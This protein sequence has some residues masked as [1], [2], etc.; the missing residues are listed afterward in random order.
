MWTLR[1]KHSHS[2][3]IF[4][5]DA[6]AAR[7]ACPGDVPISR[8]LTAQDVH[9]PAVFSNHCGAVTEHALLDAMCRG[10]ALAWATYDA[11]F[12]PILEAYARRTKIPTGDW[13]TCVAEVLEDEGL[14]LSQPGVTRPVSLGAYL[15]AAVRHRYL[16]LK[17]SDL[18]RQRNQSAASEDCS[19]E[20]VVTSLCSE[21]ALRRSAGVH[22]DSITSNAIQRLSIDLRRALT[23]EEEAI[24]VWV[25]ERVPH[26][27][28]AKWLGISYDACTKRIWRLCR[29]LRSETT[30]RR[31]HY[32]AAEQRELD[33]FMRRASPRCGRE[34]TR[35]RRVAARC[36]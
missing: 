2:R 30:A 12:R 7:A 21:D 26:S 33:R 28:I 27:E 18:C 13:P 34:T 32:S 5:Y 24:L 19:G 4:C 10:D 6:Q 9:S 8:A 3:V 16:R 11:R 17:R 31:A 20:W 14:R 29:R 25:G 36:G 22:A 23:A 35:E 15:I 1:L